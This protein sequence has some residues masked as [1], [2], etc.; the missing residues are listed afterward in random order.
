MYT[1]VPYYYRDAGGW[2]QDETVY[3][4]GTLTPKQL[5]DIGRALFSGECFIPH[6][7]GLAELQLRAEGFP[8]EDDHVWHILD[9]SKPF[10]TLDQLPEGVVSRGAIGDWVARFPRNDTGWDVSGCMSRLDLDA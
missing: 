4:Q 2:Q 6:D 8:S 5:D 1:L 7:V 3:F 10:E 9:V